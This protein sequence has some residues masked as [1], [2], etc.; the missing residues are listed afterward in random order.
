MC[1]GCAAHTI[2]VVLKDVFCLAIWVTSSKAPLQLLTLSNFFATQRDAATEDRFPVTPMRFVP[3][4]PA[5]WYSSATCI[6]SLVPNEDVL[7]W[8]F[9]N[10]ALL[11]QYKKSEENLIMFCASS[12]IIQ[13]LKAAEKDDCCFPMVYHYF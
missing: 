5:R 10:D 3:P 4:F 11:K 7:R 1:N 2:N 9:E 13:A 12:L 6:Q 8:V